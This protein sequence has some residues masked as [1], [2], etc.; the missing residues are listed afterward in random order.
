VLY[1]RGLVTD[2][3]S[4]QLEHDVPNLLLEAAVIAGVR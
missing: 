2:E 3:Y 1:R 4:R